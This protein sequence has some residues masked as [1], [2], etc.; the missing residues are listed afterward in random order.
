MTKPTTVRLPED[1]LS[2]LDR[3]ARARGKDRATLLRELLRAALD[4][5][6]EDEVIAAYRSGHTSTPLPVAGRRAT[7]H[8]RMVA[9]RYPR[10]E[11]RDGERIAG[12]L[13]G[14]WIVAVRPALT[15]CARRSR[16]VRQVRDSPACPVFLRP[17]SI[18][19]KAAALLHLPS[20]LCA[21]K[22]EFSRS[23][24]QFRHIALIGGHF[25]V[26]DDPG[27]IARSGG[28]AIRCVIVPSDAERG[29]AQTTGGAESV[30]FR[31]QATHMLENRSRGETRTRY[32][33]KF[34]V[35]RAKGDVCCPHLTAKRDQ[36]DRLL[37]VVQPDRNGCYSGSRGITFTLGGD[38]SEILR[39]PPQGGRTGRID[40]VGKDRTGGGLPPAECADPAVGRPG[41]TRTWTTR[42]GDR[43]AGGGHST[44]GREGA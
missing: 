9:V 28:F 3:R 42:H 34:R 27:N 26:Q 12:G 18:L 8:R 38:G 32:S 13:E 21:E 44:D 1:V 35:N 22:L 40:P 41:R 7:R 4:R 15:S 25:D 24:T 11:G 39:D 20:P 36:S 30:G 33:R 37:V 43:G 6:K 29:M 2:E 16:S 17:R 23:C 19:C 5:D 10:A 31:P 14:L